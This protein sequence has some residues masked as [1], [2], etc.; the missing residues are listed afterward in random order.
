MESIRNLRENRRVE[1]VTG[2]EPGR[3]LVV[4]IGLFKWI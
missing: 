1:K 2:K 4:V 3:D